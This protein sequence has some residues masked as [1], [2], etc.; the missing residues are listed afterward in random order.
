MLLAIFSIYI[1]Y[2]IGIKFCLLTNISIRIY[3]YIYTIWDAMQWFSNTKTK[4]QNREL[5]LSFST[6]LPERKECGVR[7][8]YTYMVVQICRNLKKK[9]FRFVGIIPTSTLGVIHKHVDRF[10][11]IFDPPPPCGQ[12]WFFD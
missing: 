1:P 6:T 8:V 4:L 7:T 5:R 3:K 2:N 11:D 12:T 9:D 10:L